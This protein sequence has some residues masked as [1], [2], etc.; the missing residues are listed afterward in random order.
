M[1]QL[2]PGYEPGA[3]PVELLSRLVGRSKWTRKVSKRRGPC[4]VAS[5]YQIF[6]ICG[7][8]SGETG[9][10]VRSSCC[11]ALDGAR[12][13]SRTFYA[14]RIV[15]VLL[16]LRRREVTSRNHCCDRL[17]GDCPIRRAALAKV[18]VLQ[19]A[20]SLSALVCLSTRNVE[21]TQH[22]PHDFDQVSHPCTMPKAAPSAMIWST[23]RSVGFG[24]DHVG[25]LGSV[26]SHCG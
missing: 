20:E 17:C 22:L 25:S 2:H 8:S 1:N 21:Q 11:A 9:L 12:G 13:K 5:G 18:C 23:S 14:C 16:R 7:R 3:L 6:Q 26:S 24:G 4:E 19:G 15:D 10:L